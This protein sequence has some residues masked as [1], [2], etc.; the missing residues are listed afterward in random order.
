[1]R[2]LS[3]E[4]YVGMEWKGSS[5]GQGVSQ[6]VSDIARVVDRPEYG[7]AIRLRRFLHSVCE[8]LITDTYIY[9]QRNS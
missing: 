9:R 2:P 7:T 4:T 1:M 3:P 8:R 5:R 6:R